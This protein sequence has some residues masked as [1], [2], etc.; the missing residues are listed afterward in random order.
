M[1]PE[2]RKRAKKAGQP[3]GTYIYT[4]ENK[5]VTPEICMVVYSVD[6]FS[7]KTDTKLDVEFL[8]TAKPGVTWINIEGLQN[9]DLIKQVAEYYQLH[10][11]TVEDILNNEQ[12]PKLEEFDGYLF[13]AMKM[14]L[15]IPKTKTFSVEEFSLVIGNNFI[16][17]FQDCDTNIFDDIQ[18]RLR[19]TTKQRIR[20]QG[21]DYL[22]YRLIDTI[23]DQYFVVLEG[24]GEEIERVEE[25]IIS[26]PT[27]HNARTIYRLK[28]QMLMLRKAIWPMR[29][30]LSHLLQMNQE[31][32]SSFTH[33]YLRD[34]YDH[35]VQAIDT[36]ETFRDMLSGML[37]IYLSSLTARMNEIMKVLTMIA[38]VF[39]PITFV[40]SIFGMNFDYMP[41]LRWHYGYYIALAIMFLVVIWMIIY[42]RRKKW[43]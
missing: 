24:L 2:V 40:A 3:P 4:G 34:V 8:Q 39:I 25:K 23:V 30:A 33:V 12:R 36:L 32:I 15:W 20:E 26:S 29:E 27:P 28:R 6:Q 5:V 13:M 11:L 31:S 35:A 41:E 37:D 1:F 10:P 7:E 21:S 18:H 17:T 43:L 16:L 38:T 9:I 19:A 22:A 14:L 42:F